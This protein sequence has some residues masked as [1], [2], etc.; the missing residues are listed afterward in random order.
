MKGERRRLVVVIDSIGGARLQNVANRRHDLYSTVD[1]SN[2]QSSMAE[3]G[4]WRGK[5]TDLIFPSISGLVFA[6]SRNEN[7]F[8]GRRDKKVPNSLP[9][10]IPGSSMLRKR[11]GPGKRQTKISQQP[12]TFLSLAPPSFRGRGR[13]MSTIAATLR[14]HS[15]TIRYRLLAIREALS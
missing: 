11:S 15:L 4:M 9:R 6:S 13:R 8:Q 12:I 5:R 1:L 10:P 2:E 3:P 7:S 14:S